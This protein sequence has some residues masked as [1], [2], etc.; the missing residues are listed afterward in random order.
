MPIEF[1]RLP[2]T[3]QQLAIGR[4]ALYERI[5][6]GTFP[7]PVKLGP[8]LAAW[9]QYELDEIVNAWLRSASEDEL[10]EIVVRLVELRK[11]SNRSTA[12]AA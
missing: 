10:R 12:A 5:S 6:R 11:Q 3:L 9:P 2:H 1:V 4:T 8:K 7:P